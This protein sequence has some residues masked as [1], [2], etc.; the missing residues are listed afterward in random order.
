MSWIE[1]ECDEHGPLNEEGVCPECP[2]KEQML[3]EK[4]FYGVVCRIFDEHWCGSSATKASY[5]G[6]WMRKAY[7][8]GVA[9]HKRPDTEGSTDK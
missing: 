7:E 4:D 5:L 3:A 2:T 1:N 6:D 8:A 9:Q